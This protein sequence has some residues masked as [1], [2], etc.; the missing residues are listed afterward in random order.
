M[1]GHNYDQQVLSL[2]AAASF[3]DL[4]AAS[5]ITY[6]CALTRNSTG[7]YALILPSGEGLIDA[8]AFICVTQKAGGNPPVVIVATAGP[9]GIATGDDY[10]TK[11]ISCFANVGG[12]P[13]DS[14]LEIVVQ[15]SV[16]NPLNTTTPPF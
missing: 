11:T 9:T 4:L 15:R 14:P 3:T 13:T 5:L 10:V 8:Q 12:A 2:V 7:V 1:A 16:V 6:G